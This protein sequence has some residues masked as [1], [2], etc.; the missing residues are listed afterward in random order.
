MDLEGAEYWWGRQGW[1]GRAL[2]S[3]LS[4]IGLPIL[5]VKFRATARQILTWGYKPTGYRMIYFKFV[6]LIEANGCSECRRG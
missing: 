4:G 6:G 5:P 3:A 1:A 2:P